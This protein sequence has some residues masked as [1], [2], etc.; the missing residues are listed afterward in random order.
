ML[1]ACVLELCGFVCARA[2]CE[3]R[4][5]RVPKS[6]FEQLSSL[7]LA[8]QF[9]TKRDQTE[10]KA[11]KRRT[12]FSFRRLRTARGSTRKRDFGFF[13]H[14]VVETDLSEK[15]V[16]FSFVSGNTVN[17]L[18]LEKTHTKSCFVCEE[19]AERTRERDLEERL[20]SARRRR[21]R[22]S[23]FLNSFFLSFDYVRQ[24]RC[25]SSTGADQ[26]DGDQ[27]THHW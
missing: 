7:L 25:F 20:F 12:I 15:K 13:F 2:F 10:E 24:R 22:D 19:N 4:N 23:L 27:F 1:C 21:R 6:P 8:V 17:S 14:L 9:Q 11:G 26:S 5:M 18:L 16:V 3:E